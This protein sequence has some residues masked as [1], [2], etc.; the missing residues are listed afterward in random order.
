MS[1]ISLNLLKQDNYWLWVSYSFFTEGHQPI[2]RNDQMSKILV[3]VIV[4]LLAE[5]ALH[6]LYVSFK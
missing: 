1:L 6:I 4:G 5:L 2:E 3:I